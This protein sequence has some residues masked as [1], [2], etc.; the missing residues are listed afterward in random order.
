MAEPDCFGNR[1]GRRLIRVDQKKL[2]PG[3]GAGLQEEEE[4]G[5]GKQATLTS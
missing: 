3:G 5:S 4:R 1:V 2:Q